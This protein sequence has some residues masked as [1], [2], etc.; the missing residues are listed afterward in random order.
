MCLCAQTV[1]CN[2]LKP[3]SL[4]RAPA[5]TRLLLLRP[6]FVPSSSP[7]FPGGSARQGQYGSSAI[8]RQRVKWI[9]Y[10]EF[11]SEFR[12]QLFSSNLPP[13]SLVICGDLWHLDI[14]SSGKEDN[15]MYGSIKSTEKRAQ[16]E[17]VW[18]NTWYNS[19]RG[20]AVGFPRIGPT[21]Y[22]GGNKGHNS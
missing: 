6:V 5:C 17:P 13:E 2:A 7:G 15:I 22:I 12:H 8:H 19:P 18:D 1:P 14:M 10:H 9:D 4:L 21:D 20:D 16:K 3:P 11:H